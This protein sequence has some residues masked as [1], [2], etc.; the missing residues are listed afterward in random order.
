MHLKSKKYCIFAPESL[1]LGFFFQVNNLLNIKNR[2]I[3]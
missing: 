1:F 2:L 3:V